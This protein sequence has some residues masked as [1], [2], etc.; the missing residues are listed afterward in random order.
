MA[1]WDKK[2]EKTYT[3]KQV[4]ELIKKKGMLDGVLGS[5]IPGNNDLRVG[6][7][8]KG[9]LSLADNNFNGSDPEAYAKASLIYSCV[10]NISRTIAGLDWG[11]YEI[12]KDGE[13]KDITDRPE[14]DVLRNPCEGFN[15]RLW[16]QALIT[17][18]ELSGNWYLKKEVF[19]STNRIIELIPLMSQY[20]TIN[21]RD[22]FHPVAS[23]FYNGNPIA[24]ENIIH[25]RYFNPMNHYIGL[26]PLT[27]ISGYISS[28][29]FLSK[30][31]S[32]LCEN[33]GAKNFVFESE[34]PIAK[35]TG[36][37]TRLRERLNERYRKFMGLEEALLLPGGLKA[38]E[39]NISPKEAG[40]ELID[41]IVFREILNV[42]DMQPVILGYYE[43]ANYSNAEIQTILYKNICILPRKTALEN[44]INTE[45][46]QP[47]VK[48]K[49]IRYKIN[50]ESLQILEPDESAKMATAWTQNAITLNQYLERGLSLPAVEN[51]D[52]YFY[53]WVMGMQ[54]TPETDPE[55]QDNSIEIKINEALN[56]SIVY[57]KKADYEQRTKIWQEF[58]F[59]CKGIERGIEQDYKQLFIL[60]KEQFFKEYPKETFQAVGFDVDAWLSQF[61][62]SDLFEKW[63]KQHEDVG[64]ES[65]AWIIQKAVDYSNNLIGYDV[66]NVTDPNLSIFISDR[67]E[68][69]TKWANETTAKQ[70]ANAIQ[71]GIENA[72][73]VDEIAELVFQEI[74]GAFSQASRVR[75]EL[76][77]R[78]E[79]VNGTNKTVLQS[80][81]NDGEIEKKQWITQRDTRVRDTHLMMDG[82][83]V[84]KNSFFILPDG[85][86]M[87]YP[88][89]INER[90]TIFPVFR[91]AG[92]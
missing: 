15:D 24:K 38:R 49:N 91:K 18:K 87:E 37:F 31:F 13:E 10:S 72:D 39:I 55:K 20:V 45:I 53:E 59:H 17:N 51:G 92:D 2:K 67:L 62:L 29:Y 1:F 64:R 54:R 66:I 3:E 48:N 42:F 44:K 6:L 43:S 88:N 14:F 27:A 79:T 23:Y 41:P 56:N 60:Q 30:W 34:K 8:R 76:I 73:N 77:A 63:E 22:M 32:A 25:D 52:I 33:Q 69:L 68:K 75:A 28:N 57:Q 35:T 46:V 26:S 74:D 89:E 85:Q 81:Q 7:I 70:V 36:A 80:F 71:R 16:K 5:S 65:L 84:D 50:I 9:L 58:D 12:S 86:K 21:Q 40:I 4:L 82:V 47:L 78:T 11:V 19:D 83:E 90:C 61:L